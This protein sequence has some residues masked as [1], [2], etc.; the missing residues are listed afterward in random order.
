M[1]G[2]ASNIVS[3]ELKEIRDKGSF[4]DKI[5]FGRLNYCAKIKAFPHAR[6]F[7]YSWAKAV[8][9]YCKGVKIKFHIKEGTVS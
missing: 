2:F 5:V 4:T 3:Q 1:S 8:V 6:E 7:Y 9:N